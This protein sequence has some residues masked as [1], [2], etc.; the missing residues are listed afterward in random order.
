MTK[1]VRFI[2]ISIIAIMLFTTNAFAFTFDVMNAADLIEPA[3]EWAQAE[4]DKARELGLLTP[5][6][7]LFFKND[8]TRGQ[9]AELVVNMVEKTVKEDIQPAPDTTFSDSKDISVLKAYNAQIVSGTSNTTFEPDAFI[10]REQIATML[11]RAITYI[12]SA[13]EKVYT[14]KDGNIVSYLDKDDVS[15]W[16][17][18]GVGILASNAI[19]KGTSET[20]LSPKNKASIEQC[21]ILV[22]RLYNIVNN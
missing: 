12:E 5:N 13:K 20:T 18:E 17:L 22:Y 6:T 14:T 7:S 16:A 19:M 15:P 4:I 10:T 1:L 2:T 9:F 11:Y 21:V 3:S 8:I